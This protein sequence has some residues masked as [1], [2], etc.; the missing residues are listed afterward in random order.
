MK[1]FFSP[2][3]PFVRKC[4]VSAAELG[5]TLETL[6]SAAGPVARD[7]T[8]IPENP[9]GQVPT[10]L[11]EDDE[12]FYD[13]RVICEFLDAQAGGG[14]LFPAAG[15]DRWRALREQAL[16]DGLLGAAL[17]ARYESVLRPQDKQWDD[18]SRGQMDKVRT[19]LDRFE[20]WA[21][22]FGDRVDIGTITAGCG[23]GYLEFRFPALPWREARPQLSAWFDRFGDR[24]SMVATKP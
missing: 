1:I 23:L 2:A 24:P 14:R 3:S 16:G 11:V 4:M 15:R 22:A 9:L 18:W 19:A 12:A 17:L 13:S 21:D 10:L 6:P 5:L 7:Q 20:T 8:I